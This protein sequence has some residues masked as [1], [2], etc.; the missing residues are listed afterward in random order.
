[1]KVALDP[2]G[3]EKAE[4]YFNRALAVFRAQQGKRPMIGH[5]QRVS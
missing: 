1:L 2:A 3:L 5:G 4:T